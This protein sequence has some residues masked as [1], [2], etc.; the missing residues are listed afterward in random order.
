MSGAGSGCDF[1][2]LTG[3]YYGPRRPAYDTQD[4]ATVKLEP[5]GKVQIVS[6]STDQGQGT[7][8]VSPRS[9]ATVWA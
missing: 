2:E 9:S 3:G 5:S 7:S 6:K 1:V 4:G 8:T